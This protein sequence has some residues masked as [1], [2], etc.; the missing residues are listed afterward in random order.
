MEYYNALLW[1]IHESEEQTAHF[2]VNLKKL[3]HHEDTQPTQTHRNEA[4]Q[5]TFLDNN[6]CRAAFRGQYDS[7]PLSE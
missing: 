3:I 6:A 5:Q 1:H 2:L 4:L 7:L